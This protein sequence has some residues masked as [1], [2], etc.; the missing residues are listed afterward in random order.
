MTKVFITVGIAG[1]GKST[2]VKER[3]KDGSKRSIKFSSDEIRN[4]IEGLM[5][6]DVFGMMSRGLE[7][8]L[9]SG[10]F[11]EIYYD[12]TNINRKRRRGLYR[13]IKSWD[14]DAEVVI[15]FFSVSY[16]YAKEMNSKRIGNARVPDD[17]I[18]RM[19]KQLQIPRINVDCDSFEVVGV[20]IFKYVE[21]VE[22]SE[23]SEDLLMDVFLGDGYPQWWDEVSSI[24]DMEHDCLPHHTES[25]ME[26]IDMCIRNAKG[27][28]MKQIARFHDLGKGI[29]KIVDETG[30][31]AFRGHADVSAHYFL[32]YL[33]LT[34]YEGEL[35]PEFELD[36]AETIYQHMN[37]HNDL[38]QK[39][40]RN[41][42]LTDTV[43]K[44]ISDF[45]KIDEI[46][47]IKG[48]F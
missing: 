9:D 31:G 3:M 30:Y 46:S 11:D 34:K 5:H 28:E 26:H 40:I 32:N 22:E 18:F 17:V 19:H 14:K 42:R 41:N 24:V 25:V 37:G 2:W 27:Y 33:A 21:A 29:T 10:I 43:I 15:V 20:P 12:A 48:E 38:G 13:N 44:L 1:S 8:C 47:R 7:S 6:A 36:V 39:N 4:S 23:D 16:N 45:A 35:I